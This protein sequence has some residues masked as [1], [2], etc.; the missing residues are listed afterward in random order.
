MFKQTNNSLSYLLAITIFITVLTSYNSLILDNNALIKS[1]NRKSDTLYNIN[2]ENNSKPENYDKELLPGGFCPQNDYKVIK[3]LNNI[4]YFCILDHTK[5]EKGRWSAG[6]NVLDLK[7]KNIT[8]KYNIHSSIPNFWE[9]ELKKIIKNLSRDLPIPKEMNQLI[10]GKPIEIYAWH[11]VVE[12]PFASKP[13][14][15]NMGIRYNNT[16]GMVISFPMPKH[17]FD[18]NYKYTGRYAII[19]HEY[20]HIYQYSLS[21][22]A[23]NPKWLYEGSASLFEEL[24]V[25]QHYGKNDLS[26]NLETISPKVKSNPESFERIEIPN[27]DKAYSA[28]TFMVLSLVNELKKSGISEVEAYRSVLKEF[29]ENDGKKDW[30]AAFKDT[31]KLSVDEFYQKL[32]SG[33]LDVKSLL[34]S[35]NLKIKDIFTE[36][37]KTI[38]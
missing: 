32:K 36:S 7:D 28:S 17:T 9:N 27:L 8:F 2:K 11:T 24:Y 30:K 29:P 35:K 6:V 14:L 20:F 4:R 26:Y 3:V 13:E 22:F 10:N 5:K 16:Q 33:N 12:N 23:T 38:K 18:N 34:P 15:K 19:A 31:F 25:Q 21:G 1:Y 37:N